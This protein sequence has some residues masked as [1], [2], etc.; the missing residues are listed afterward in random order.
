MN[1]TQKKKIFCIGRGIFSMLAAGTIPILFMNPLQYI[2]GL[3]VCGTI[4]FGLAFALV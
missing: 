2:A 4:S 1:T 3:F